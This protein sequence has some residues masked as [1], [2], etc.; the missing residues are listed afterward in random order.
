VNLEWY[1]YSEGERANY[2]WNPYGD[3]LLF[4]YFDFPIFGISEDKPSEKAGVTAIINADSFNKDRKYKNYPLYSVKFESFMYAVKD[5]ETCLS[6]GYCDPIGG[7]SIWSTYST[8]IDPNDG[9]KIIIVSSQL[10]GNSLFHDN[11]I[12]S[13]SQIGGMVA[14]LA[15]AD[16][17]SYSEIPPD[18][19]ENHIVFTFFSGESYGYAGSQR[20]VQDIS[21]YECKITEKQDNFQCSQFAACQEPCMYVDDF[22]NITINNIKGIIELNQLTC[23]GCDDIDN[24]IYFMHVDDETDAE[25]LKITNLISKVNAVYGGSSS[26]SDSNNNNERKRQS[27]SYN[28]K[29]AWEGIKNLGL[30]PASAQ[31][32][33]KKRKIKM[34]IFYYINNK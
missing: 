31:S 12:G 16:A 29:P 6:R 3:G 27:V 26:N 32:F 28:I 1:K 21:N 10:D 20:F 22:K 30:P 7:N 25:T 4:E 9:K 24:P 5:S 33:L 2:K 11:T 8:T 34:I 19:F 18:E 17:L 15:I 14:S 13:N 23:S